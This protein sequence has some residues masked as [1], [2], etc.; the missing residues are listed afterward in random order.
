MLFK[1]VEEEQIGVRVLCS[2]Q[3]ANKSEVFSEKTAY[4]RNWVSSLERLYKPV[5]R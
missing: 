4:E 3:T 5:L 2:D 1:P